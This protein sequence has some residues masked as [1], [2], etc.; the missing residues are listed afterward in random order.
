M[1]RARPHVNA[2][3]GG[4]RQIV[5]ARVGMGQRPAPLPV[6]D[7]GLGVDD[8]RVGVR[9][10]QDRVAPSGQMIGRFGIGERKAVGGIEVVF[11]LLTARDIGISE[12]VIEPHPPG[13]S[14]MRQD[15]VEYLASVGVRVEPAIDEV[16]QTSP[17]LRTAPGIGLFDRAAALTQRVDAA[18]VI[19]CSIA[20]KADE[21]AHRNMAQSQ[22]QRVAA[23]IDEPIYPARLEP[24]GNVDMAVG[25]DHG[26]NRTLIV[27]AVTRKVSDALLQLTGRV[28]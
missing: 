8:E 14:D 12:T 26:L 16:A 28:E 6:F 7:R 11:V 19:F 4:L 10:F 1:L 23:G 22:H 17:G 13:S 3:P 18:C 25:G 15:A 5:A 27:E 20:Q 24:A 2:H 9:A 21:I